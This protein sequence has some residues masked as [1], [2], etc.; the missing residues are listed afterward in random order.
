MKDA[1]KSIRSNNIIQHIYVILLVTWE[2]I[3]IV[4]GGTWDTIVG[5]YRSEW[6]NKSTFLVGGITDIISTSLFIDIY[7]H[8]SLLCYKR[9]TLVF[10]IC[11]VFFSFDSHFSYW[12]FKKIPSPTK[13]PLALLIPVNPISYFLW[14]NFIYI[15]W[16]DS[17]SYYIKPQLSSTLLWGQ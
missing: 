2:V 5:I 17:S 6:K 11:F 8:T 3:K 7:T 9:Y 16:R 15:S 10:M 4:L 14:N 1:I 13:Y 12:W